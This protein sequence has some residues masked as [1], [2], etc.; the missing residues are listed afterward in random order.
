MRGK[1]S[2]GNNFALR[3]HGQNQ[4]SKERYSFISRDKHGS[5]K[6]FFQ[7]FLWQPFPFMISHSSGAVMPESR[8]VVPIGQ[9]LD[10]HCCPWLDS[11]QKKTPTLHPG[12]EE[13]GLVHFRMSHA[14]V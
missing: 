5:R 7:F 11:F 14:P 10:A 13:L 1:E 4:S 9:I 8:K 12:G 3:F 2:V 6:L